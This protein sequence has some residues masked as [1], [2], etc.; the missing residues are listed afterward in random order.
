L[1]FVKKGAYTGIPDKAKPAV[2][3][4][5][6]T[7]GLLGGGE[8]SRVAYNGNLVLFLVELNSQAKFLGDPRE[9]FRKNHMK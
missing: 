9:W 2:R 6:K 8:D 7:T 5:R 1:I 4:G 3:R